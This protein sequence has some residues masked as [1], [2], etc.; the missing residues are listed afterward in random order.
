[1]VSSKV[2]ALVIFAAL[3]P[4]SP[5]FISFVD[6]QP[7][8]LVICA[9]SLFL[10]AK[11][12][13]LQTIDWLWILC[14]GLSIFLSMF[15]VETL[16]DV[17]ILI[18]AVSFI[19]F[20][21]FGHSILPDF[22]ASSFVSLVSI[23]WLLWIVGLALQ[24][25]DIPTHFVADDR[26]NEKRGYTSLAPEPTFAALH[27]IAVSTLMLLFYNLKNLP[28]IFKK[29][30]LF[31]GFAFPLVVHASAT[32]MVCF[33]FGG[34]VR[35]VHYFSK[36]FLVFILF[37]N[38]VLGILL[39]FILFSVLDF[40]F[41][42]NSLSVLF[43]KNSFRIVNIWEYVVEGR[44]LEDASAFDRLASS[45]FVLLS[46]Y[47]IPQPINHSIW[48]ADINNFIQMIKPGNFVNYSYRNLSGLGQLNMFL[49]IIAL[50]PLRGVII[51]CFPKKQSDGVAVVMVASYVCVLFFSMPLSHP[52]YGMLLGLAIRQHSLSKENGSRE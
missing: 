28:P 19:I 36:N 10:Q 29:R 24:F 26:T 4:Y 21:L 13:R 17:R 27:V 22:K 51:H 23:F 44:I 20:F 48:I 34:L 12:I 46:P 32:A 47:I 41:L 49:G 50:I 16:T 6:L 14:L 45:L 7:Y 43:S 8:C 1:M 30:Y 2:N 9:F 5:N 40:H 11:L 42:Q 52:F 15:F 31:F 25:F 39:A 18:G 38:F 33:L 3:F 37:M 35:V